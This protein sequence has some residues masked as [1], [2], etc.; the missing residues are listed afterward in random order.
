MQPSTA[1]QSTTRP[2]PET[3]GED[4]LLRLTRE[5]RDAAGLVLALQRRTG[6][7]AGD[8]V[9]T[10]R[11]LITDL[12]RHS[13]SERIHLLP[14]VRRFVP[15]GDAAADRI[16]AGRQEL[17]Y[18]L[19]QLERLPI[20]GDFWV[21]LEAVDA[22][23]AQHAGELESHVFPVLAAACPAEE[24]A[25]AGRRAART[26]RT[27]PTHPHPHTPREGAALAAASPGTGLV[28]KVRDLFRS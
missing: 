4:L 24:L 20:N 26:A 12:V 18:Q 27:A 10:A 3:D 1:D 14:L 6:S 17:E 7:D 8:S 11:E 28:D 15:E 13:V 9:A 21:H 19:Q 2:A 16:D 22:L 5:H 23:V 25:D